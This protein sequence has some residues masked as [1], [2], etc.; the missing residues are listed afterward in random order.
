[1][2]YRP[3]IYVFK[4]MGRPPWDH[5]ARLVTRLSSRR[6]ASASCR[7][8]PHVP[9]TAYASPVTTSRVHPHVH[10]EHAREREP[11]HR[12]LSQGLASG[13]VRQPF[14]IRRSSVTTCRAWSPQGGHPPR[15][16]R[17]GAPTRAPGSEGRD[18]TGKTHACGQGRVLVPARWLRAGRFGACMRSRDVGAEF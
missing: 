4:A 10:A 5:S 15:Y 14:A 16:G 8:D 9:W 2:V 1:M 17:P 11:T 18:R 6:I 3:F 7:S 13:P 12:A